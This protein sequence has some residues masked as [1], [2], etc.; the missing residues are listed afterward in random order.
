MTNFVT[1]ISEMRTS[2]AS[3]ALKFEGPAV[4]AHT[5]RVDDLAPSLMALS[6]ALTALNKTVN[7]DDAKVEL[8]INAV[9]AGSFGIELSL[10][11]DILTQVVNLMSG[12]GVTSVCNAHTLVHCLIEILMLKKWLNGRTNATFTPNPEQT[13]VTVLIDN[14]T[15]TISYNSYIG[16]QDPICYDACSRIASPLHTEGIERLVVTSKESA[17]T[18]NAEEVDAFEAEQPK[19]ILTQNTM[20]VAVLIES[21]SFRDGNKWRVSLGEKNSFYASVED[22]EFLK[23][24]DDRLERFGKG[25][26][27]KVDL[28]T[29]QSMVSGRITVEYAILKVYE[30]K[31]LPVQGTLF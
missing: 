1:D 13:K 29:T 5:M 22:E 30:H 24:V 20:Q 7:R 15:T 6:S 3:F 28:Q 17:F 21:P 14:S 31:T 8:S 9:K 26:L 23:R 12:Q 27:L 11:Q 2:S 4:D 18:L 10:N 25:D 19:T 16:I